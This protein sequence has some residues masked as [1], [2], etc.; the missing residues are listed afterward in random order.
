MGRGKHVASS[1]GDN[2]VTTPGTPVT[3]RPTEAFE[4]ISWSGEIQKIEKP[5]D[6][7]KNDKGDRDNG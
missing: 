5:K 1:D 6:E 2:V 4:A 3:F 7:K